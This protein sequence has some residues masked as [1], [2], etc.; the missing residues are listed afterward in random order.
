MLKK[1]LFSVLFTVLALAGVANAAYSGT[2]ATPSK[3]ANNCYLISNADELYGF[4]AIVNGG[5][6]TACGK[7]TAN[8]EV[9]KH[10]LKNASGQSCVND[11]GSYKTGTCD[12]LYKWTPIGPYTIVGNVGPFLG[13]FDGGGFTI[14]GL[15]VNENIPNGEAGHGFGLFGSIQNSS[16]TV[17][18]SNVGVEDSYFGCNGNCD[19]VGGVVGF[20]YGTYSCSGSISIKNVYSN[21]VVY[22]IS[23]GSGDGYV[24]GVV[25]DLWWA[26]VNM[27]NAYN[28]G[29]VYGS[30][31]KTAGGLLGH[32]WGEIVINN[33][34]N[35]GTVKNGSAFIGNDDDGET[36][37][38]N[39][40]YL[41]ATKVDGDAATMTA[42]EFANGTVFA[43]L[44]SAEDGEVWRQYK[45]DA[46]PTFAAKMGTDAPA[47]MHVAVL[48]YSETD[49][50]AI[51]YTQGTA[52]T[53][54]TVDRE[55]NAIAG[56]TTSADGTGAAITEIPTTA[57]TDLKLYPKA[58]TFE[59]NAE[60]YY[61]IATVGDLYK[62]AEI[63]NNGTAQGS[64]TALGVKAKLMNDIEVNQ[65]VLTSAGELNA[66]L[67]DGFTPW[68]PIGTSAK[69]F[70]GT[71]LGNGHTIS[72]L[73]V[74]P[75]GASNATYKGLFGYVSGEVAIDG[76]G[77][78]D[79]YIYGSNYVGG[80][81]GGLN[82]G[83][84]LT[85]SNSF[86]AGFVVGNVGIGG[87]VGGLQLSL[88]EENPS[89]V[90]INNSY[91]LGHVLGGNALSV[92]ANIG[93]LV[94]YA[95][96]L[97]INNSYNM[98]LVS[99]RKGSRDELAGSNHPLLTSAVTNSF[100]IGES[101]FEDNGA[102]QKSAEEF[103]DGT[104]LVA[105]RSG[106]DGNVWVQNPNDKYPTI[107]I[108]AG[109]FNI[110]VLDWGYATDVVELAKRED[111][112]EG[113]MVV[114]KSGKQ[115]YADGKIYEGILTAGQVEAIGTNK[116][117]PISGVQL[118][119]DDKGITT[120]T[121]NGKDDARTTVMIPT[122]VQVDRVIYKRNIT[123]NIYTTV[124]LPFDVTVSP[125][126]GYTFYKFC[127]V[128]SDAEGT[129]INVAP[130]TTKFK[131]NR[132]YI[133]IANADNSEGITFEKVD[134]K[135]TLNTTTLSTDATAG[136]WTMRGVYE[137]KVWPE[138]DSDLGF[139]Y[140]FAN[141]AGSDNQ[142]GEFVEAGA[143]ADIVP[144]RMYLKETV[145]QGVRGNGKYNYSSHTGPAKVVRVQIVEGDGDDETTAIKHVATVPTV[146]KSNR[147][148][149]VKGRALNGK[150][151]AKGTYYYNGQ[152]VIIK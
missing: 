109:E 11:D 9:N 89:I 48:H 138:G 36:S 67:T 105:L 140:G 28:L 130:V 38:N 75:Q 52:L 141:K 134:S 47:P 59:P 56:W 133:M 10:V 127:G 19:G 125:N 110:L 41:S 85:I 71:F 122:N 116:L 144:M 58:K 152:R 33:S 108:N 113:D 100:C 16:E 84:T 53:L 126:M 101:R 93:G 120:A 80:L 44:R 135:Y 50:V 90:K 45:N 94:G 13:N 62:F 34:F 5:E 57:T 146:V 23:N 26:T 148:F 79:S 99:A 3:D 77:I 150:P 78:V 54:P 4:A 17:S 115:F 102:T 143:G 20:V 25:G 117:Y 1:S 40:Y 72:G 149:D 69:P 106:D 97:T 92:N 49:S 21:A 68:T 119:T 114:V 111:Y 61:E 88:S 39:S 123:A 82:V 121:L 145:P 91:N 83:T 32:N 128:D 74:E 42:A 87:L 24:G 86:N 31:E 137:Y 63:V 14:S 118:A 104:V 95:D 18:I 60:G 43:A 73:Y 8:I 22:G 103:A 29:S 107:D 124:M 70:K 136:N 151:T 139:V 2:P 27:T 64:G 81:V 12:G 30:K 76:V 131:A 15:Y 112:K 6:R 147:W 46:Y 142:I 35:Y 96:V 51:A 37:V 98:G 129:I 7:L 66:D 132:P 65:N 55:G